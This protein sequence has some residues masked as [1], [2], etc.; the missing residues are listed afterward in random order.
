MD[1]EKLMFVCFLLSHC[2]TSDCFS[3]YA[4]L[5]CQKI[6]E[7]GHCCMLSYVVLSSK[8]NSSIYCHKS[9]YIACL[10]FHTTRSAWS[11]TSSLFA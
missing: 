8:E 2:Y 9:S 11:F 5:H 4:K 6:K 1:K 10:I 7:H 3:G